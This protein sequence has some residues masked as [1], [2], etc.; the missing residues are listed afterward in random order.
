[1]FI[2]QTQLYVGTKRRCTFGQREAGVQECIS[3][4]GQKRRISL[5]NLDPY[6]S[7]PHCVQHSHVTLE[8]VQKIAMLCHIRIQCNTLSGILMLCHIRAPQVGLV[9]IGGGHKSGQR[10]AAQ[11]TIATCSFAFPGSLQPVFYN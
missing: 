2:V 4:S 9:D 5:G 10:A 6:P 8:A 1:M 3:A 11:W 7:T